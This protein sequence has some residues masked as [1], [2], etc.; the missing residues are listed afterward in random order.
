MLLSSREAWDLF[1]SEQSVATATAPGI[2]KPATPISLSSIQQASHI[3]S[4]SQSHPSIASDFISSEGQSHA[5]STSNGQQPETSQI[6]SL[7]MMKELQSL[8]HQL[9]Q[10]QVAGEESSQSVSSSSDLSLSGI[11]GSGTGNEPGSNH[12]SSASTQQQRQVA[13]SESNPFRC[14]E[15]C[16]NGRQFSNKSN[17]IRHQRERR[18]ELPKLRCSFCDA[19]FSRSSARNAHEASR[20]CR[21]K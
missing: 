4:V 1:H 14:W 13:H 12:Y 16:C 6:S 21:R 18:G 2:A 11:G 3:S 5:T 20:R 7:E 19:T 17:F 9:R 15:P 10:L 8:R